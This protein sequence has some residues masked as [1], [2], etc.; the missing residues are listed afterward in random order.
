MAKRDPELT[1]RN[2]VIDG[3]SADLRAM[4]PAVLAET[5]ITSEQ[6]LN[7][8]YGGKFAEYIDIKNEV[9]HSPAHFI[10]LYLEGFQ[11]KANES[12]SYSAHPGNLQL[13]QNSP[14]L[15][16]Y[17]FVFLRRVY[18]RNLD[19][20]SKKRPTVEEAEVWIGQN[21]ANYGLL[22]T[23][24]FNTRKGQWENDKSE[25]RH[26]EQP[27]WTIGHVLA[28]GL[29]I[30]GRDERMP[31][32]TPDDYLNF[33]VNVIVRNSGSTYEYAL[34]Q[35]YREFVLATPDPLR[36]PLLIPE[37]RYDG[38]ASAHK[39]RLDFTTIDPYQLTKVGFELSPWSTHGYLSKT[40]NLTAAEINKL[41]SDNFEREMTKHKDFFRKHGI[42]V[43]IYTDTDLADLAKLFADMKRYLEPKTF[44][45]QIRFHIIRDILKRK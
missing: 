23:P 18:L 9:I 41:A 8:T 4:L 21:N 26:F 3:L 14:R 32:K 34:A 11:R 24:R 39:Y 45:Q 15:Q 38:L 33:F 7:G 29:V 37:F 16:E 31:F 40:K 43:M 10:A 6:S 17:M 35:M 25:I 1:A 2:K 30:P 5:G 13:L 42:L 20:L 19:A 36:V 12:S 44:S 28:S 27:Y 22:I